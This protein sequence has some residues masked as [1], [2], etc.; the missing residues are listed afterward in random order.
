MKIEEIE[1]STQKENKLKI[2]DGK[3]GEGDKSRRSILS[4][5]G[6]DN[7]GIFLIF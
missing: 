1:C 5:V 4:L 7:M 3:I 6:Y 2:K